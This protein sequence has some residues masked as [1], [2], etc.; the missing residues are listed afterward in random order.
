MSSSLLCL[1]THGKRVVV[2]VVFS[3]K[4]KRRN[5]GTRLPPTLWASYQLPSGL[6]LCCQA[7]GVPQVQGSGK[8]G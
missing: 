6:W 7:Q 4:F 5:T 3:M 8:G 1:L 2:V